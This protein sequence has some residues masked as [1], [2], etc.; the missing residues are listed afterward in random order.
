MINQKMRLDF[1][2][3]CISP[4]D[5]LC[6]IVATLGNCSCTLPPDLTRF[7]DGVSFGADDLAVETFE[8]GIQNGSVYDLLR[9]QCFLSSN[10]QM[11]LGCGNSEEEIIRNVIEG[12]GWS[13]IGISLPWHWFNEWSR[14]LLY[15]AIQA[16]C[17]C[18][19]LTKLCSVFSWR[20]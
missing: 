17:M 5:N 3:H 16:A 4:T 20:V 18:T 8:M 1:V 14:G 13:V 11:I 19:H 2:S 15:C 7:Y 10:T 9:D 12:M 6:K